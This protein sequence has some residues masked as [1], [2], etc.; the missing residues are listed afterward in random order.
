MICKSCLPPPRIFQRGNRIDA[1]IQEQPIGHRCDLGVKR[2]LE[3][4]AQTLKDDNSG[5][6]GIHWLEPTG[7][8]MEN[9]LTSSKS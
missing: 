4:Q 8:E 3:G 2:R 7:S 6:Q 1:Q 9:E 5:G